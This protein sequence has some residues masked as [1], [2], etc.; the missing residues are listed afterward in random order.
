MMAKSLKP[1][2]KLEILKNH[3]IAAAGVEAEETF[4][5]EFS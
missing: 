2:W 4:C 5:V 1:Q 3:T